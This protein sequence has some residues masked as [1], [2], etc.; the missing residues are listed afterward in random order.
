MVP[1]GLRELMGERRRGGLQVV[2]PEGSN[3][4]GTDVP[5]AVEES[6]GKK[7]TY[8]DTT[9][10]PV[11]YLRK[12]NV[13]EEHNQEFSVTYTFNFLHLL[14]EPLLVGPLP[15]LSHGCVLPHSG[16]SG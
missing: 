5:F 13:V 14:Q 12:S 6:F 3:I 15:C 10:R 7:Y 9:G 11:L 4:V 2:L 1:S 8:L 16:N